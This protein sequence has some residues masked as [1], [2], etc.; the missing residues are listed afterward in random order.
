MWAFCG[1]CVHSS[2]NTVIPDAISPWIKVRD[3]HRL[4]QRFKK[5]L[6]SITANKVS[7]SVSEELQTS[8]EAAESQLVAEETNSPAIKRAKLEENLEFDGQ[9]GLQLTAIKEESPAFEQEQND[10]LTFLFA[11]ELFKSEPFQ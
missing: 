6:E 7:A 4:P 5:C 2:P 1:N 11:E 10:P 8:Q 3:F 9:C